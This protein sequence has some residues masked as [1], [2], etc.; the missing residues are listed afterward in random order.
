MADARAQGTW[1]Y[2]VVG[3]GSAGCVLANRLTADGRTRVLLLEA[4]GENRHPLV[5]IPAGFYKLLTDARFNWRFATEPDPAVGGRSIAIPRGKGL[6]GSSAINGMIYVRGQPLDYDGWAQLGNRGWSWEDVEPVF[7]RM[8]DTRIPS[9]DPAIRGRGGIL[10]V[11]EV[12]EKTPLMDAFVAAAEAAG[13]PRNPDYNSGDQEGFG[14]YQLTQSGNRRASAADVYLAPA[15][16]RENLT[17][18]TDAFAQRVLLTGRKA[19]G[20]RY[21]R[22]GEVVEAHAAREV[23]LAAGALQS[24]QLLE[25]SGIGDGDLLRG[26]GIEVV[27]HSPGVGANYRDHYATRASW[28][29]RDVVT[30]NERSRGLRF[31]GEVARYYLQG[32]GILTHGAGI[33]FGFVRTRENLATPDVQFFL[34]D[35]SYA[36][37]ATRDLHRQPGMT[38]AIQPLRSESVGSVHVRSPNPEDPPAIRPNFF[39]ARSDQESLI[40]GMKIGRRIVEQVPLKRYLDLELT[41]GR[42]VR[43]DEQLLAYG[44][45]TGQTIYHPVGTA[46]MGVDPMA[47][48]DQRLRVQGIEGLRVV[49]ASVMPTIVSG[50]TNGPVLMIAERASA[51]ILE[52]A[53]A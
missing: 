51:M 1:D 39:T 18:H 20:V 2:I 32:R 40:E 9:A 28:R 17:I 5:S 42:D 45:D 25:L 22:G 16:G 23:I 14:Y 36:D 48:V 33:A 6:G 24:P 19:T 34:A 50:N 26:F 53:R 21:R 37:P 46:K 27:H 44:R 15:R 3:A 35:A 43:T 8:E 52:D 12:R 10:P 41:P 13:Y 4:G 30:L 47:V 38:L 49:D 29:L 31:L 7:R 11:Q